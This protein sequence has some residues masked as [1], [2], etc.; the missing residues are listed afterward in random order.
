MENEKIERVEVVHNKC[1]RDQIRL[2]HIRAKANM[3]E[4]HE[5]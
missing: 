3:E 1:L 2:E 5:Q 4:A